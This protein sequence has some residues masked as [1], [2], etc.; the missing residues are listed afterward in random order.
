MSVLLV[1]LSFLNKKIKVRTSV[2]SYM[3]VL[4]LKYDSTRKKCDDYK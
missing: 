1:I 4:K 3:K 2:Q